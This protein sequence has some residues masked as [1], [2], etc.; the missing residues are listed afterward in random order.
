MPEYY[1]VLEIKAHA[2]VGQIAV[3]GSLDRQTS[4]ISRLFPPSG[5]AFCTYVEPE[6]QSGLLVRFENEP[7]RKE[8]KNPN[9]AEQLAIF[10]TIQP[11]GAQIIDLNVDKWNGTPPFIKTEDI[12]YSVPSEQCLL[13]RT[14]VENNPSV[15]GPWEPAPGGWEPK[16][17]GLLFQWVDGADL[18]TFVFNSSVYTLIQQPDKGLRFDASDKQALVTWWRKRIYAMDSYRSIIGRLDT[19]TNGAWKTELLGAIQDSPDPHERNRD[20]QRYNKIIAMFEALDWSGEEW[21]LVLDSEAGQRA[22]RDCISSRSD[23]LEKI[24]EKEV[25]E[26]LQESYQ[27][28]SDLLEEVGSK[29]KLAEEAERKIEAMHSASTYLESQRQRLAHDVVEL[30]SL[31][32]PS[33]KTVPP[34]E[35]LGEDNTAVKLWTPMPAPPALLPHVEESEFIADRLLPVLRRHA[36]CT[37]KKDAVAFHVLLQSCKAMRVPHAGW[38]HA[39]SAAMGDTAQVFMISATPEWRSFADAWTAV[40]G[41][42]WLS[43]LHHPGILF[44]IHIQEFAL[45]F[46]DAWV[47]PLL[48]CIAGYANTL[49]VSGSPHWPEN[50]RLCWSDRGDAEKDRFSL[51]DIVLAHFASITP[52]GDYSL[53]IFPPVHFS[54][55]V[56]MESWL[57]WQRFQVGEWHDVATC[58]AKQYRA[59]E[60]ESLPTEVGQMIIRDVASIAGHLAAIYQDEGPDT[61]EKAMALRWNYGRERPGIEI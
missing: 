47:H 9:D 56:S 46:P 61:I 58:F 26:R 22:L 21:Q 14:I 59:A 35:D 17:T 37:R 8:D 30:G 23:E 28:L 20:L 48:N 11:I 4:D 43:A 25:A 24:A 44:L 57:E 10:K 7:N 12:P 51:P 39:Y 33:V 54:G 15:V 42:P 13:I 1:G 50:L 29:R 55:S 31:L 5:K 3:H 41:T 60:D 18:Q 6:W 38:T 45:A 19:D 53:D 2:K 34:S 27:A 32:A 40:L 36:P 16:N 49:P 52:T